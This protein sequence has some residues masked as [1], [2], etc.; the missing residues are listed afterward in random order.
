MQE[1]VIAIFTDDL[2]AIDQSLDE[3]LIIVVEA[4]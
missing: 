2:A 4:I 1:Y 3:C